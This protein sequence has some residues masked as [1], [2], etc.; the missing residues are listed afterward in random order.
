MA[1]NLSDEEKQL[2]NVIPR[3]ALLFSSASAIYMIWSILRSAYNRHR[4][5]HRIML[6]C[7]IS[8]IIYAGNKFWG[9][10][11]APVGSS[12]LGAKGNETTCSIQGFLH[13]FTTLTLALYYASL[14]FLS[15]VVVSSNF[16]YKRTLWLEKY[17]H[18]GVISI[19]LSISVAV[20]SYQAFN[21]VI[22]GCG[23]TS[24]PVGCGDNFYTG[25]PGLTCARGPQN[26]KELQ[27]YLGFLP[28]FFVLFS[29]FV[30]MTI[31][32]FKAW[33]LRSTDKKLAL[34]I[35]NQ[36]GF[37]LLVTLAIYSFR[38][39][40]LTI[41]SLT[42]STYFISHLLAQVNE[43]LNGMWMLISYLWFRTNG[44]AIED[45]AVSNSYPSVL[46]VLGENNNESM[47]QSNRC[48]N[49]P[50][51]SIFDGFDESSVSAEG[52]DDES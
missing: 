10:A 16:C 32:Y 46:P 48:L 51:H 27:L 37:Y 20:L 5:Y 6:G 33:R 38:V 12:V 26:I 22:S 9:S 30:V 52:N 43:A 21:P 35:A 14:S 25:E 39:I 50:R 24:D 15:Y 31:V 17:V 40:D 28:T 36:T 29:P 18:F 7:A 49:R 42:G 11:A 34:S 8:V 41:F 1:P 23:F 2:L 3:A 4:V 47:F 44:T 45:Q 13:V 19:P